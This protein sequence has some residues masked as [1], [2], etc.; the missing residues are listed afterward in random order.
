ME[1]VLFE[2][3]FV[4]EPAIT[5]VVVKNGA[6]AI[7]VRLAGL[8]NRRDPRSIERELSCRR[9]PAQLAVWGGY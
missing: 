7:G 5:T 1:T 8:L 2:V 3:D 6:A 9:C 4:D